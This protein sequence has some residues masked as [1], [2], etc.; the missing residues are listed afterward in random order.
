MHSFV[1]LVLLFLITSI[2][3]KYY[4]QL[5]EVDTV[6]T[7]WQVSKGMDFAN[8]QFMDVPFYNANGSM[9]LFRDRVGNCY[10]SRSLTSSPEK[11]NI[12]GKP[13]GKVEW[14]FKRPEI[15]YYLT[16]D[17]FFSYVWSFNIN[18]GNAEIIYKTENYISEISPPHPDG[19]HLLLGAKDKEESVLEV[20]SISKDESIKIPIDVPMHRIRFTKSPDLTIFVNRSEDPKTSWLVNINTKKKTQIYQGKS[21]S[22]SWRPG[23]ENFCFYG[24]NKEGIRSLLILNTEGDIVKNFPE[25]KNHTLGWSIDGKYIVT[26]VK[27]KKDDPYGGWICVVDYETGEISKI[28]K[29]Q[30]DYLTESGEKN[31]TGLPL[32]QLSP[33]ATKVIYNSSRYGIKHPHV[34]VSLVRLPEQVKNAKMIKSDGN[35][36]LSWSKSNG[37]EIEG[38]LVFRKY[39]DGNLDLATTLDI[40]ITSFSEIIDDNIKGYQI[41]AK[42]FSGIQS[43]PVVP[44]YD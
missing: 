36:E 3:N 39:K 21:T 41:V 44:K 6:G 16:S 11:L 26:D 9:G 22:P 12:K 27:E 15:L 4:C 1:R 18:S 10:I 13:K 29:Y 33:D 24:D 14:D 2:L 37:L 40:E 19:D 43:K 8:H 30:S 32:P 20:Y 28:V 38:Y 17:K 35:V 42:E 7:T 31:S 34:F 23:G 25:L 5:A